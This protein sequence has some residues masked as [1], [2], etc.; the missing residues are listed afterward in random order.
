[1]TITLIPF[2][3]IVFRQIFLKNFLLLGKEVH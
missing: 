3:N 2:I 1:M